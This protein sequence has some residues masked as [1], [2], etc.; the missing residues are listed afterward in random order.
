MNYLKH[1]FI[2]F[3]TLIS[4]L[5]CS[6]ED[7]EAGNGNLT[8]EFENGFGNLGTIV[9]DNTTQTSS[10]NQKHKFTTLKYI[11][12]N[13]VLTKEDGSEVK[14]NYNNPDLGAFIIDQADAEGG[15]VDIPLFNIPVANYTKIKFGLGI[16]P[17]AYLLGETGQADF[18]TKAN[19]KELFWTWAS[20]YIFMKLE[21]KYG[22]STADTNFA[23]H[24]GNV[25]DTTTNGNPNMYREISLNLPVSAK[26]RTDI[27]PDIHL[28]VDFNKFLDG[29]TPITLSGSNDDLMGHSS[30][31]ITV[32]DN[33]TAA[34]SVDHV[35]ND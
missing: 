2:G 27:T 28:K 24:V 33:L 16:S 3:V 1:L 9:L 17:T 34:F 14:Y 29:A 32:I 18:L 12:S 7:I 11:I 31:L 10:N 13:V 21:G 8:L 23:N 20:G 22:T 30:G 6:G 25:G 5:S 4:I 35:H 19:S 15:I 26:V